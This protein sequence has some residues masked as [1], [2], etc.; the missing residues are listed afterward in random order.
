MSFEII[1]DI[2]PNVTFR[3]YF[4]NGVMRGDIY[5]IMLK[6]CHISDSVVITPKSNRWHVCVG[7]LNDEIV[8]MGIASIYDDDSVQRTS[9]RLIVE[10]NR[11]RVLWI[12]SL[13]SSHRGC[14]RATLSILEDKLLKTI[15]S[16]NPNYRKNIYVLS[17]IKAC[18]FY[19]KNNYE[20]IIQKA[21]NTDESEE[22]DELGDIVRLYCK[23][24]SN[25]LD[26]ETKYEISINDEWNLYYAIEQ[27]RLDRIKM[28]LQGDYSLDEFKRKI[29][30]WVDGNEKELVWRNAISDGFISAFRNLMLEFI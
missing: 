22:W 26:M 25:S 19:Y 29:H 3:Y 5:E 1:D 9:D 13:W 21:H 15:P 11:N 10:E 7:Y 2:I 14:G 4:N 20:E 30:D 17:T 23:P 18:G 8:S 27:G 12:D 28:F 24:I 16:H 6:V